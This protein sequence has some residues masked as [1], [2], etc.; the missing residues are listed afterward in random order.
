MTRTS[1]W[2]ALLIALLGAAVVRAQSSSDRRVA[3]LVRGT[4]PDALGAEVVARLRGELRAARFA[5][6][7]AAQPDEGSAREVIERAAGAPGV[8]AAMGV[9]F[10]AGRARGL[11]GGRAFRTHDRRVADR[12]GR[13]RAPCECAGREGG[14]PV[15]GRAGRNSHG[16]ASRAAGGRGR[17]ATAGSR[18]ARRV[19]RARQPAESTLLAG[20][21]WL[22]AGSAG[23]LAPVLSLAVV[24]QHLGARLAVGGLGSSDRPRGRGGQRAR[25]GRAG[26]VRAAGLLAIRARDA[27]VR[28][29]RWRRRTAARHRHGRERSAS[30]VPAARCGP[31]SPPRAPASPGRPGA[32]WWWASTP[33]PWV[34][35]RRRRCASTAS[36]S[37]RSAGPA[38]G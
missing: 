8:V 14:R 2:A 28:D 19:T 18:S 21:G 37:P 34:P 24:R 16:A 17:T 23:T 33:A 20:V 6:E 4:P 15:A 9:F 1:A 25:G 27:R 35:G 30:P 32:G 12:S 5:V 31:V 7:P 38:S 36:R 3:F 11:G 10:D 29:R 22:R 26:V 13:R